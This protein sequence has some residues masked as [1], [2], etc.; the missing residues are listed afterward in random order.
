MAEKTKYLQ[1]KGEDP[2]S[3]PQSPCKKPGKGKHISAILLFLR[4]D[5]RWKQENP[6]FV[7]RSE[8]LACAAGNDKAVL[9]QIGR[10]VRINSN[11]VL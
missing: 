11:I 2:S 8:S 3:N 1:H 7:H 9:P 5:R 10:K 4:V 6:W